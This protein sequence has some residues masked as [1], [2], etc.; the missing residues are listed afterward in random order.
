MPTAQAAEDEVTALPPLPI[1]KRVELK[2]AKVR[3][4]T[5][6]VGKKTKVQTPATAA[7]PPSDFQS[8]VSASLP[9]TRHSPPATPAPLELAAQVAELQSQI[10]ALKALVEHSTPATRHS[11]P[12][13]A[14]QQPLPAT[15]AKQPSATDIECQ[16][17]G[18]QAQIAALKAL[19]ESRES[20]DE[21]R[22][23]GLPPS[24]PL[25]SPFGLPMA[26]YPAS[27][28]GTCSGFQSPLS[29]P[30]TSYQLPATNSPV[31][32]FQSPVSSSIPIYELKE[33]RPV[34]YQSSDLLDSSSEDSQDGFFASLLDRSRI[35]WLMG[36]WESLSKLDL[37]QI[38][39][40]PDR[41][42]LAGIAAAAHAELANFSKAKDFL[43]KASHWGAP[44][45]LLKR[46]FI[47]N[48]LKSLGTIA[49]LKSDKKK[50]EN[51]F[52]ASV[53]EL[54]PASLCDSLKIRNKFVIN[55]D[56][57][58]AP[59]FPRLSQG[60]GSPIH[61]PALTWTNSNLQALLA[62]LL[63]HSSKDHVSEVIV[64][65]NNKPVVS[66]AIRH[67]L[68]DG[69]PLGLQDILEKYS[70]SELSERLHFNFVN[71]K[72]SSTHKPY[73]EESEVI[74]SALIDKICS[75]IT[76]NKQ[77]HLNYCRGNFSRISY[78]AKIISNIPVG[79]ESAILDVGSV[80]PLLAALLAER[81]YSNIT[82]ADP[83]ASVFRHYINSIN[84]K[85]IDLDILATL[86]DSSQSYDLIV[87][88]EVLEH[89][90]G[91]IRSAI[92]ALKNWLKPGGYLLVSTPN[93]RSAA[94]FYGLASYGG[95]LAA[96]YTESVRSQFERI[97]R[98]GYYGHL[99]E[100]TPKEVI[101]LFCSFGFRHT[102][103]HYQPDYRRSQDPI[104]KLKTLIE[105][106]IPE[107][108]LFA[109]YV[110]QKAN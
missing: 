94:G 8:Q 67:E 104:G 97:D 42:I 23:S 57:E 62:G 74:N 20:R 106:A 2:S 47:S 56:N 10:S 12:V 3:K 69:L 13:T 4:E 108:R 36:D 99:R 83:N 75:N 22:E 31:S 46:L 34:G 45:F 109:R 86:P 19:V 7:T 41:G 9:A 101:D 102:Q 64:E 105:L 51:Y 85:Y 63:L 43:S 14:A 77:K 44:P 70:L 25:M 65:F 49:E 73:T 60:I 110:F 37:Q 61:R 6:A 58:R 40:H 89:L 50:A 24:P 28:A 98:D 35:Q 59:F 54:V 87:F 21:N 100:F 90:A 72:G 81:G 26:G 107:L 93:L 76:Q 84:A 88:C 78:D 91:D 92:K 11:P 1:L 66:L 55:Q 53:N 95:G 18:M 103:T 33:T 15:A 32:G 68:S 16:V 71:W 17:A 30:A 79:H 38:G 52:L 27:P 82:I 29:A 80:P 5:T 48:I 96:K 39:S